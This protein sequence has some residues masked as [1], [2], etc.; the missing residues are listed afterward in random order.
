[1]TRAID[2]NADVGEGF[3]DAELMPFLTSC[4]IACG[5]HAGDEVTMREALRLAVKHGLAIGAHPGFPDRAGFGRMVTATDS[6]AIEALVSAQIARLADVA[7]H[8]GASLAHVKPHGAL[9]D[10][11]ARDGDVA[12]AIARAVRRTL[13]DAALLLLAGSRALEVARA[14]GLRALA[15][16][17]ADRG[18]RADGSLA[19][20]GSAGALI[21]DPERAAAQALAIAAHGRVTT[22][23]GGSLALAADTLCLH[24]DTPGATAIA[25][26]V[27]RRLR[28]AGIAVARAAG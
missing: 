10:L 19:P 25:E 28:D 1:M 14:E 2:L 17:F 23:D 12:R 3:A 13:P 27:S 5:G 11:A 16:G 20:R 18:Y 15:E 9:Y 7:R 8:E 26:R 22:I 6:A 24:S 21:T 4:S